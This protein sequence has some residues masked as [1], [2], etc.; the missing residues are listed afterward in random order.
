MA[1]AGEELVTVQ[2][3]SGRLPARE[4]EDVHGESHA[5]R[6]ARRRIGSSAARRSRHRRSDS[7]GRAAG[8][9][10]CRFCSIWWGL[11]WRLRW[12][13]HRL[14]R[15]G[16]WCRR[17]REGLH[18]NPFRRRGAH[19]QWIP[20]F[21]LVRRVRMQIPRSDTLRTRAEKPKKRPQGRA[22]AAAE[23][24]K[25]RELE[26]DWW[27][28]EGFSFGIAGDCEGCGCWSVV[29]NC[30]GQRRRG[31]SGSR[32]F[33][34][35]ERLYYCWCR[36]AE[37]GYGLGG[38]GGVELYWC[39]L[40]RCLRL[41]LP[42]RFRF[43]RCLCRRGRVCTEALL[44]RILLFSSLS[45]LSLLLGLA[46]ACSSLLSP[47]CLQLLTAHGSQESRPGRYT[48]DVS[49][50]H[51]TRGSQ[52]PGIR[53][54]RQRIQQ[55]HSFDVDFPEP[56]RVLFESWAAHRFRTPSH[57]DCC[58]GGMRLLKPRR[59]LVEMEGDQVRRSDQ[60]SSPVLAVT[61]EEEEEGWEGGRFAQRT[62]G[63]VL[64][65]IIGGHGYLLNVEEG[66]ECVR[67]RSGNPGCIIIPPCAR[68]RVSIDGWIMQQE[69]RGRDGMIALPTLPRPSL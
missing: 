29:L 25:G 69:G 40:R 63:V 23:E 33:W 49:S 65:L 19:S 41:L 51:R 7:G 11:P 37:E 28:A 48:G 3:L 16:R 24:E 1:V 2:V 27:I 61:A 22:E 56:V 4:E 36:G 60:Y 30:R 26:D 46:P 5:R 45:P 18:H 64:V 44:Y 35:V 66:G 38:F 8:A 67:V 12:L 6:R 50:T 20:F 34:A 14:R 59:S 54:R 10:W 15:R 47:L 58:A 52:S 55:H 39:R 68:P 62:I 17:S 9:R 31:G 53:I 42:V 32:D 43:G 13:L 21:L 57:L